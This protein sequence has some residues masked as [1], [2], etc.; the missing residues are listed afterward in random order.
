MNI[1]EHRQIKTA[2]HNFF[3]KTSFFR[4]IRIE[5]RF[6]IKKETFALISIF[7]QNKFENWEKAELNSRNF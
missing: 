3:I 2:T 5:N 1:V 7:F 4:I 6:G